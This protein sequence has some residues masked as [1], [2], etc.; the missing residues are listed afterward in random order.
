MIKSIKK[1]HLQD[2]SVTDTEN[3]FSHIASIIA[4]TFS[5]F[6]ENKRDDERYGKR[7]HTDGGQCRKN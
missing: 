6:D 4:N 5:N 3:A 7:G 2:T 1:I